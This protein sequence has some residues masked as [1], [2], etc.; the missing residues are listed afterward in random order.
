[1]KRFAFFA[2]VCSALGCGPAKPVTQVPASRG[3]LWST[4]IYAN[5]IVSTSLDDGTSTKVAVGEAPIGIVL[6]EA[7]GRLF[8]SMHQSNELWVL[9]AATHE[10]LAKPPVGAKPYWV[11]PDTLHDKVVVA[12]SGGSS[13]SIIDPV[14]LQTEKTLN[15]E[16]DPIGFEFWDEERTLFFADYLKNKVLCVSADDGQTKWKDESLN[17]PIWVALDKAGGRLFVAES[18]ANAVV[19]LDART[20]AFASRFT[21]G[22][23][24]TGLL[25]SN[26]SGHLVV[27]NHLSNTLALYRLSDLGLAKEWAVGKNPVGGLLSADGMTLAVSLSGD[28]SVAL[29]DL[30]T[31]DVTLRLPVGDGPRGLAWSK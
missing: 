20:G 24:P 1:M 19:V 6:H 26:A 29:L 3:H 30:K 9:D 17:A 15:V 10:V 18:G 5:Q 12:N 21:V 25:V 11:W 23:S 28:D 22:S 7:T 4:A 31:L 27:M 8:V 16:G 14:S 2:M 13:F